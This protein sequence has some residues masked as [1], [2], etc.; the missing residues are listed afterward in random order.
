MMFDSP[1]DPILMWHMS[2]DLDEARAYKEKNKKQQIAVDEQNQK[3][4]SKVGR[5]MKQSL[6]NVVQKDTL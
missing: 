3:K 4:T 5:N 2:K 6:F 1:A